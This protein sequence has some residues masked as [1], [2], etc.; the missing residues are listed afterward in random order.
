[1]RSRMR[2]AGLILLATIAA[3]T[4]SA[5][6]PAA[7]QGETR[8]G[9]PGVFDF[10]VLALSWSSGFCTNTGDS[11]GRAQCA[12]GSQLGF[13]VHGLWPQFERGFPTECS[14]A[15]RS[16]S[17]IA[18]Q[19]T[20]GVFPDENLARYEWRKHGTC[21]GQSPSDYFD[22]VRKAR[23]SVT[24]PTPFLKPTTP[25]TWGP[26]D[27]KRA[28]VAANGGLRADMIGIACRSG[29]LEEVRI[30]LGKDLR[31]FISCPEVARRGCGTREVTVP[32][33][34]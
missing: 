16:P 26:L 8:N 21:S 32:P 11:Q 3:A 24:V 31:G 25:Q 30:C 2:L 20:R 7:A 5:S 12:A 33:I 6:R 17:Q 14:P 28:F 10:Y 34:R 13:T 29:V 19:K 15:A 1:M 27:I 18:L 23:D 4:L 9:A 22:D